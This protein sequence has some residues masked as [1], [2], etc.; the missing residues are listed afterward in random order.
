M[1]RSVAAQFSATVFQRAG[2]GGKL[3]ALCNSQRRVPFL[4]LIAAP[5]DED[6][7]LITSASGGSIAATYR[8][9]KA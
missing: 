2:D 9:V 7:G 1:H 6:A 4:C 3:G 8:A 5:T